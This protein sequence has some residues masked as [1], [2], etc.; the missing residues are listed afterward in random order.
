MSRA[1]ILAFAGS[2]RRASWNKKLVSIAAQGAQSAGAD[3]TLIDLNDYPL[4]LY[5]GDL[6]ADDGLPDNVVQL[7]EIFAA[8][9]GLL[10]ACPEY[11]SSI[12]PLLKNTI[13]WVSRPMKGESSL[14]CFTGKYAALM[15]TSPG[16]LGGLR[17]L[18]HVRSIL[19]SIGVTVVPQQIAVPRATQAFTDD[20]N[21][22]DNDQCVA[23]QN[24]GRTLATLLEK[25]S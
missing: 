11:N 13:D 1:N 9:N 15:S 22:Q 25:L 10:I 19:S 23:V 4:P 18:T 6:E 2:A 24:L 7:K 12:T 21:L 16:G 3:V 8:H 20:G 5:H 17:G 14:A